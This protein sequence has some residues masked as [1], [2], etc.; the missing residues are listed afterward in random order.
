MTVTLDFL[1][2]RLE[3]MQKDLREVQRDQRE[4]RDRLMRL[5]DNF[6]ELRKL[7]SY[8]TDAL[9]ALERR[10]NAVVDAT[11]DYTALFDRRLA[12]LEAAVDARFST[13]EGRLD[14]L[15]GRFDRL[16]GRFD[17][18]EDLVRQVLAR[19]PPASS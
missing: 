15:E 9:L 1:G 8:Q 17:R 16:E 4:L 2:V 11:Q 14:N 19:L 6:N 7:I 5:E 3:Q 13:L 18:L 10:F 12:T